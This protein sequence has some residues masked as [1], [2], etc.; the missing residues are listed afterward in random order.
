MKREE[1]QELE[2]LSMLAFG[3]KY[4]W[5][6]IL[7]RGLPLKRGNDLLFWKINVEQVKAYMIKTLE[8]RSGLNKELEEKK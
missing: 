4:Y 6:K 7:K 3:H 1:N 5:R 8:M 2:E